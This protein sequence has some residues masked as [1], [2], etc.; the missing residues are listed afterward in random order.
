MYLNISDEFTVECDD[1]VVE[2]VKTLM[3]KAYEEA[4][5]ALHEWHTKH[6]KWFTGN[7]LPSFNIQL[8]SG[9]AT[10]KNYYAIH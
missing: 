4:S 3:F 9:S 5:F 1:S 8:Q 6:S 7:D 10:G 2:D